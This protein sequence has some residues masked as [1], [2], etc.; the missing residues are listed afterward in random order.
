MKAAYPPV[1]EE[2]M[3]I[4]AFAGSGA[5][6]ERVFSIGRSE[7]DYFMGA[8]R[9]DHLS[10]RL[11][12]VVSGVLLPP[13]GQSCQGMQEVIVQAQTPHVMRKVNPSPSGRSTP[14]W[15]E[16]PGREHQD[17]LLLCAAR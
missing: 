3:K 4:A 11:C 10:E 7:L 16:V 8:L 15:R 17:S 14:L 9:D 6:L 2:A 1:K 12:A 13:F 5:A